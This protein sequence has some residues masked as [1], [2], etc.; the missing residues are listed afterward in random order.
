MGNDGLAELIK[1]VIRS[2]TLV[3]MDIGSNDI[4]LEGS[5]LLFKSLKY[6]PSLSILN[7]ANHDRL[8]RNRIGVNACR[9]LRDMIYENKILSQLNIADNRIGNDGLKIIAPAFNQ[10]CTLA[11]LNLQNNDLE[12]I[13]ISNCL[14]TYLKSSRNLLEINIGSNNMGDETLIKFSEIFQDNTCH[15]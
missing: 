8:H 14:S 6:H 7:I 12:G 15:L 10:E 4:M 5:S 13:T 3:S 9:D 2:T 11:I 1:G